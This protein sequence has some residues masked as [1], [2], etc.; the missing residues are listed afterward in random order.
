[1]RS[2][3][4]PDALLWRWLAKGVDVVGLSIAFLLLC[5]PVVTIGPACA[6]LYFTV[7]K[8]LRQ[9]EKGTFGVFFRAFR[10]NLKQGA[11]A[12]LICLPVAAALSFG[13]VVMQAHWDTPA[14]AVMFVAYDVAL[15]VPGGVLVWLFP[16]M[17][18]FRLPTRELF[19]NAMLL[20][21]RHLPSTVVV[22]LLTVEVAVAC[23]QTWALGLLLPS[24]C[25]LL[26]SLFFERIF[27][28][29]LSEA[30]QKKLKDTSGKPV[31]E[32][33]QAGERDKGQGR[34]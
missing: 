27:P 8:C 16:L 17:G 9:N 28:K 21:L 31:E 26:T 12:T 3:F 18:R 30:E 29:Y 23:L 2:V 19:K 6:A 32:E 5:L 1:M 33:D 25:A 24:L 22:V 20:S 15:L 10:D 34:R 14:G 4:D 7:V 13:F 11:L